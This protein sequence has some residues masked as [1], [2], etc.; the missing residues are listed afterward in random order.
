M[1]ADRSGLTRRRMELGV[2]VEQ[3]TTE[4]ENARVRTD[5]MRALPRLGV[6]LIPLLGVTLLPDVGWGGR[7]VGLIGLALWIILFMDQLVFEVSFGDDT[8]SIR[9]LSGSTELS[10]SRWEVSGAEEVYGSQNIVLSEVA[11]GA[12]RRIPLYFLG[13]DGRRTVME[14]LQRWSH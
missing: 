10:R 11:T 8:I 5:W 6:L 4:N 3:R 2:R 7:A 1:M 9:R 14:G 12:R 13:S